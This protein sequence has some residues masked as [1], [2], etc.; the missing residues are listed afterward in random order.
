MLGKGHQPFRHGNIKLQ[1]RIGIDDAG[2]NRRI[3]QLLAGLA[4]RDG[5]HFQPVNGALAAQALRLP[6]LVGQRD[7]GIMQIEMARFGRK[8]ERLE[9]PA[10][11][12]MN[13]VERLDQ[14]DVVAH[15]RIG[16]GPP[17]LVAVHHIGGAAHR[18]EDEVAAADLEIAGG[19][20][21]RQREGGRRLGQQFG[22]HR[23]V[24]TH[25]HIAFIDGSACR[26]VEGPRPGLQNPHADFFKHRERRIVN[27]GHIVG[28][29]DFNRRIG[30]RQ[31]FPRAL[32]DAAHLPL[33]GGQPCGVRVVQSWTWLPTRGRSRRSAAPALLSPNSRAKRW[34]L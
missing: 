6:V 11:F 24:K 10:A 4:Q 18:R 2:V 15:L 3:N 22:N 31:L 8:I 5:R 17:A 34:P 9:G 27:G 29:Q 19:I 20:A 14:L 1:R 33:W 13:D 26:F 28:A 30:P 23:A 7:L 16:A 21:R 32:D 12:L 25:P